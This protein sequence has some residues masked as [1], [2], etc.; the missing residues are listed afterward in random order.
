MLAFL[1]NSVSRYFAHPYLGNW[2][3]LHHKNGFQDRDY[4]FLQDWQLSDL[5]LTWASLPFSLQSLFF[6]K[7]VAKSLEAALFSDEA[8][9]LFEFR[10]I[11]PAVCW[12]M[13]KKKSIS[14]MLLNQKNR[15]K[16]WTWKLHTVCLLQTC[17]H[18]F[19]NS[20]FRTGL[21]R[22]SADPF[23]MHFRTTLIESCED[24][25]VC[26]W[27]KKFL[28]LFSTTTNKISR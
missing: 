23:N 8:S 21:T 11:F 25:T 12:S 17:C 20:F 24:I 26:L 22:K 15:T 19:L 13:I 28:T 9:T 4:I 7:D 18:K 27:C 5:I 6:C 3:T 10:G 1:V 2:Q 16:K 14:S